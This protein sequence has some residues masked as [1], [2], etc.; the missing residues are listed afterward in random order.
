MKR[1]IS[2]YSNGFGPDGVRAAVEGLATIG[3]KHVELALRGH[4]FGGLVIPESAV[5]TPKSDPSDVA[6]FRDLLRDRQIEVSGCNVGGG[7]LR[8]VDGYQITATRMT[9]AARTFAARLVISGAGQPSNPAERAVVVDHLRRLGDL[10]DG[11]GMDLALETHKG[12]T[13]NAGAMLALMAEVDHPRVR[14]NFDTGNIAYYNAGVD[15]VDELERVKHLVRSV[16]LKD[17]RGGFED[18]Y[19]PAI[20][21]GGAVDFARV[22]EILDGV[23]FAGP[24]TIEIEGIGG[25]PEPGLEVRRDRVARSVEHLRS[26]GYFD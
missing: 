20:G 6:E 10:A 26:C 4:D 25:E 13:Q 3:L 12:P 22:R 18:W 5:I 16:H 11:L 9:F 24:Y 7:D 17:N 1:I 19:F 15:P 8:T 14:L 2:C 21:E 23:E